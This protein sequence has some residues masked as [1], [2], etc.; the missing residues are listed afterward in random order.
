MLRCRAGL[1]ARLLSGYRSPASRCR[2]RMPPQ[3]NTPAMPPAVTTTCR[4][5]GRR[6]RRQRHFLGLSHSADRCLFR[7]SSG[8]AFSPAPALA[9][10]PRLRCMTIRAM[11]S[12]R[13]RRRLA[14]AGHADYFDAA[15]R[16]RSARLAWIIAPG[17]RQPPKCRIDDIR[18]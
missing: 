8:L 9:A 6:R 5:A 2:H 3:G 1:I 13:N 10:A 17:R 7:S 18:L 12:P 15:D 16:G 4:E 11:T 14:D